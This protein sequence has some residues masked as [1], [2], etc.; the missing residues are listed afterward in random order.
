MTTIIL[1]LLFSVK[2][3]APGFTVLHIFLSQEEV[4]MLCWSNIDYYLRVFD[5]KKPEIVK[6]QIRHETGN[7]TSRFCREQNNL[8][9]MRP[10]RSRITTAIGVGNHMAIYRSWQES[11]AD[12]SLWQDKYYKGGDYYVFL[13]KHC[14]AVD[15]KY[16]QKLKRYKTK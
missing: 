10:A 9:G 2:V 8:F 16:I 12:Y 14:Y 5:I 3:T 7:L 13:K 4:N 1:I 6:A 15:K 11:L